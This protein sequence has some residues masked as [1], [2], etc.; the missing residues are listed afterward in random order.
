MHPP[1]TTTRGVDP[2]GPIGHRF[3]G[4]DPSQCLAAAC[5]DTLGRSGCV[6]SSFLV[7][8]LRKHRAEALVAFAHRLFPSSHPSALYPLDEA[9]LPRGNRASFRAFQRD[10]TS[11]QVSI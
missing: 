5:H 2:L 10:K 9:L 1:G 4:R 11:S 3:T 6:E 8:A 7:E